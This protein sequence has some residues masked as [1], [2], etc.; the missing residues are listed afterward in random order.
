LDERGALIPFPPKSNTDGM[1]A[2]RL[3]NG[4]E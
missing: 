2:V 4:I 3:I 1:F